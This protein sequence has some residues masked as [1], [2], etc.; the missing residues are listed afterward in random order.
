M[1]E[2]Q[3]VKFP[4]EVID[5]YAALGI[6]IL[7]LFSAGHLGTRMGVEIVEASADRVVGTMPVEGNTQPYGLLHGGASA[8]L[9]E[10]LGSVGS[11]LHG[12]STKI[13]VGVDLNCTH[14]RGVR[15]GL[16]TGV[17]TP[18]HQGRSTATYEIVISDQE[19]RRV[20]TARLTCLLR[21]V[22]AGDGA[23]VRAAH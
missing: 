11:M 17:A 12:G 19:G 7:A 8:V 6:D 2:Q 1:G 21:D 13:A 23:Q 4:Q 15:S 20:C 22:R 16:V 10:T 18:V 9:A 3:H 5:E 14:H